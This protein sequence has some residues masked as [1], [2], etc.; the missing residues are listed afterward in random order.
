[1]ILKLFSEKFYRSS[2]WRQGQ[3]GVLGEESEL[4]TPASIT[5]ILFLLVKNVL[6]EE[7]ILLLK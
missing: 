6:I 5:L 7:K 1:M 3:K 4:T 2:E